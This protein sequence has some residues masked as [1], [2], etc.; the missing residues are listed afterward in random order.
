MST[1]LSLK[2]LN[3]N[4]LSKLL[5]LNIKAINIYGEISFEDRVYKGEMNLKNDE[6][7]I[8]D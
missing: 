6:V 7:L 3:N 8:D 4:Q 2:L 5:S 1:N